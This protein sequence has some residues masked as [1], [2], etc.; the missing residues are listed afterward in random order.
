MDLPRLTPNQRSASIWLLYVLGLIPGLWGFYLGATGQIAG[1]PVRVFEH[2]LGLWALRFLCLSLAV[3]PLRQ[4]VGINLIP[5]RR[6]LG[7][8]AFW[9]VL[10][11]VSVYLLLDRGLNL[12]AIGEDLTRRPYI[13]LGMGALVALAPLAI[14]SNFWSMRKLG[15]NWQALH[16]LAYVALVAGLL[17]YILS[18]KVMDGEAIFYAG[19]TVLLLG[20]RLVRPLVRAPNRKK[21]ARQ[22][23]ENRSADMP[24]R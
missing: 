17:H 24:T 5:W 9:Y 21:T 2:L 11:H 14:T 10:A 22:N 7:L 6:A 8:L 19:V 23:T 1:D 20:Y 18:L 12:A 4:L 13:M 16:R 15:K 3:T